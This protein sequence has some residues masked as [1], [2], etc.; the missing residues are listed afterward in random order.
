MG[1]GNHRLPNPKLYIFRNWKTCG[2]LSPIYWQND[3]RNPREMFEV[4][5]ILTMVLSLVGVILNIKKKRVCF[6]IWLFTNASW[7]IVDAIHGIWTQ[8]F[9]MLVYTGLAVWGI[10]EWR[11]NEA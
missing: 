9:L 8:S 7:C 3:V 1:T 10:I 5:K 11:K 2:S 4:F 6:V